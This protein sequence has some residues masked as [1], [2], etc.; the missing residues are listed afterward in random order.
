MLEAS[1]RVNAKFA[2][3]LVVG[4]GGPVTLVTTGPD[5]STFH[6]TLAGVGST[7]LRLSFALAIKVCEPLA[8][9]KANGDVQVVKAPPPAP[10]RLHSK[11]NAPVPPDPEN[12]NDPVPPVVDPAVGAEIDVSGGVGVG[13]GVGVTGGEKKFSKKLAVPG[14]EGMTPIPLW[15]VPLSGNVALP[16]V[17]VA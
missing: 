10:S 15:A 17:I 7:V 1:V 9:L 11:V 8:R 12:T 6:V 3:V 5:A 16:C 2:D 14:S 13:V 4:F